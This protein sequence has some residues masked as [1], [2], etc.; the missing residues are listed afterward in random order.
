MPQVHAAVVGVHNGTLVPTLNYFPNI[1]HSIEDMPPLSFKVLEIKHRGHVDEGAHSQ[2][3][4]SRDNST[5]TS[6]DLHAEENG[7]GPVQTRKRSTMRK[8]T[9]NFT[10]SAPQPNTRV[11]SKLLSPLNILSIGSFLL[12]VGLVIWAALIGDG[13]ALTALGTIS[14]VSSVVGFASWWSPV[15]RE[16]SSRSKVPPGDVVIRTREGAFLLVKC[17][18]DVARE[19]YTGTEECKY[20]VKKK[21]YRFLVALGTFL[22]MISVV[23]LGNCLFAM[24]AAIGVSYMVLNGAYWAASLINKDK[25]WD[26]S[27]YVV[28][29]ITPEDAKKAHKDFD[30]TLSGKASFTRTMWYAIRE[31]HK[32]GWVRSG[33]AAPRTPQWEEWLAEAEDNAIRGNRNWDAVGERERIVGQVDVPQEAR[34][35]EVPDIAGQHAPIIEIP[36]PA[37]K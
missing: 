29:E 20:L 9:E 18:E 28:K 12:T 22:L 13:T 24:Q 19:L 7:P 26:L 33:G 35:L 1:I 14:M 16:R 34:H 15:L 21:A 4:R 17:N 5:S 23:L 25:F 37:K 30:D 32:V 27:S 8:L 11:P 10:R 3:E 6:I 31:T 36:A 2:D